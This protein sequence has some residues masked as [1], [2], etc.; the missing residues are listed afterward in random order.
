TIA[1]NADLLFLD[2]PTTYLDIA[3]QFEFLEL[4]DTLHKEGK[5]IVMV[6]HD[7]SH[8]LHYSE[9]IAVFDAGRLRCCDAPAALAAS[10]VLQEVFG[11]RLQ[12]VGTQ[13]CI[14][15]KR[16]S[17]VPTLESSPFPFI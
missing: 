17:D 13:Y 16:N 7:L 10:G 2:E 14:F 1:Q 9:R 12:Q 11:I 8:A 5:T 4:V 6:L 3:H 15:P